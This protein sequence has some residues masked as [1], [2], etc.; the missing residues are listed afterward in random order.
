MLYHTDRLIFTR[1]RI[2]FISSLSFFYY[3]YRSYLFMWL[4]RFELIIYFIISVC[5]IVSC[6]GGIV[7]LEL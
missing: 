7:I 5:V 4:T 6:M 3:H 1:A 2:L